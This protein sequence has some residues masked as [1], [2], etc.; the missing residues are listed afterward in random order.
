[1]KRIEDLRVKIFSDG[2]NIDDF[3]ELGKLPYIKG[4]TSNPTLMKKAGITDYV[5]FIEEV[6]PIIEGK[7]ISFEVIGDEFNEMK[8]QAKKLSSFS[9]NIYVK[10]PIMNTKGESSVPL[11]SELVKSG[12]KVTVTAI[13]DLR[14]VE[15]VA[16]VLDT[17]TSAIVSVFAGRIADTGIEPVPIMKQAKEILKDLP[18]VELLWASPRELLNIF[19][20]DEV[21]CDIITVLPNILRKLR[22]VGYDLW[23]FSLDTVKMFYND[24]ILSGLKL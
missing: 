3:K 11:I 20:A 14:Q 16:K 13:L 1:M 17:K 12:V 23:E 2:A 24:A 4:F 21:G 5:S 18:N 9:N 19:Q 15:N 8:R 10:I 22:L 7:P 6:L